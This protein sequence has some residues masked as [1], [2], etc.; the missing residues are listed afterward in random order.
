[1]FSTRPTLYGYYRGLQDEVA[2]EIKRQ[3]DSFIL[4]VNEDE[5][6]DFLHAKYRLDE[7]ELDDSRDPS[8]VFSF[9]SYETE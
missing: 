8:I 4:T 2:R 9:R 6:I 1:M 7:I 5:Y 3:S